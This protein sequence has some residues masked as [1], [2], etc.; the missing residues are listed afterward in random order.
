MH[1]KYIVYLTAYLGNN[2]EAADHLQQ[3][4][5]KHRQ[6][7]ILKTPASEMSTNQTFDPQP[8]KDH[9]LDSF[10]TRHGRFS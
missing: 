9:T 1:L 4:V 6:I 10:H 2:H 3:K 8:Y 7:F 5:T